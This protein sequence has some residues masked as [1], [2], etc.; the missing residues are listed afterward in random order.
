M[1][2][3]RHLNDDSECMAQGRFLRL[4]REG[5]WEYVTRVNSSGAAFIV[6]VTPA[7]E[8]VLVE[9][10]RIPLHARTLELPAGMI[11]DEAHLRG[12]S[13]TASALREL[14]EETGFRGARAEVLA[15]GPV[16][17]GLTSELLHLVRVHDLVRV[18]GGGGVGDENIVV[19]L[20][21][22]ANIDAWLAER[23]AAGLMLEPR[24][25]AALYF[26]LRATG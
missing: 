26:V 21:P 6:A 13:V 5:R 3:S 20:A 24:I 19:H 10:Q 9:Q 22:L 25:Y 17:A 18:H 4:L 23:Q 11:G 14:E 2:T 12:E 8:L 15:T 16:A 1:N 7:R